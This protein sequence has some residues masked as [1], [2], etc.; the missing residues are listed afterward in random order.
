MAVAW[1]LARFADWRALTSL[2]NLA[3]PHGQNY[4]IDA[5][6]DYAAEIEENTKIVDNPA[7]KQANAAVREAEKDL[8]AAERGRCR[9]GYAVRRSAAGRNAAGRAAQ[10]DRQH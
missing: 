7:R 4:G 9:P 8:A 6:C 1:V 10:H 3:A 2:A 5:I